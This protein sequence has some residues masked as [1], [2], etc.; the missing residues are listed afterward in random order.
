MNNIFG[1]VLAAC[2]HSY[3][4]PALGL[5][6]LVIS[7]G[8]KGQSQPDYSAYEKEAWRLYN[9]PNGNDLMTNAILENIDKAISLAPNRLRVEAFVLRGNCW[10]RMGEKEKAFHD[11]SVAIERE[12]T[13]ENVAE[14]FCGRAIFWG[15]HNE[16]QKA[17]SDVNRAIVLS[18]DYVLAR[19]VR[20]TV[21]KELG[22]Y[23]E[24]KNEM[25]IAIDLKPNCTNYINHNEFTEE[26]DQ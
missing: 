14:A 4:W 26:V 9:Q 13:N 11:W 16:F 21:Y 2:R 22:M 10:A 19:M 15:D 8:L 6:V 7:C 20:A 5:A 23:E 18:S 17:L 12:P 3:G 25:R 24:A 1:I